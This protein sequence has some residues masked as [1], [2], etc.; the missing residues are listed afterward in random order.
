MLELMQN[1]DNNAYHAMQNLLPTAHFGSNK[2][3]KNRI[4]TIIFNGKKLPHLMRMKN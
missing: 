4:G 2:K 3:T 1:T